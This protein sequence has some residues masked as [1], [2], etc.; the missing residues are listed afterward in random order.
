MI[1]CE[2]LTIGLQA[3]EQLNAFL[4]RQE[5]NK[6]VEVVEAKLKEAQ[7]HALKA[8][9]EAGPTNDK[10]DEANAGLMRARRYQNFLDVLDEIRKQAIHHTAKLT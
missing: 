4:G 10:M 1:R 8:A 3:Q 2:L 9:V 7:T 5:F 6:I